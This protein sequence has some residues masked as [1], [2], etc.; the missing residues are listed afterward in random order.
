MIRTTIS[1]NKYQKEYL[2]SNEVNIDRISNL[3]LDKFDVVIADAEE[4]AA[5][6]REELAS[7]RSRVEENGLGLIVKADSFT[8]PGAFYA[9]PF[10][11][12]HSTA[13]VQKRLLLHWQLDSSRAPAS[14][15]SGLALIRKLP[16]T[17]PLI[18][19]EISRIYCS[20]S[21]YGQGKLVVTTLNNTFS[22]QLAGNDSAYHSLW[23]MILQK[24]APARESQQN[25][26]IEPALPR[27]N[28]PVQITLRYGTPAV[29]QVSL[30]KSNI[31]FQQNSWLPLEW[32]GNFW[33]IHAGWQNMETENWQ[34]FPLY[35][36][37]STKWKSVYAYEKYKLTKNYANERF[38]EIKKA[39]P[40]KET[41]EQLLLPKIY[42]FLVILA[43]TGY[44]WWE[45]KYSSVR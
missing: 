5:L 16:G 40:G 27:L 36:F 30:E 43:C 14:G 13:N 31:Y 41:D 33:P 6:T 28:E 8:V 32:T 39:E 1:R 24:A 34:N 25:W 35:V 9:K 44:L 23:S 4:L 3:L 7:I 17:Q 19:D 10:P 2:N 18:S 21:L 38:T 29:P 37:E 26:L 12:Y 42:F 15:V 20:S 22:W 45:K 11:V